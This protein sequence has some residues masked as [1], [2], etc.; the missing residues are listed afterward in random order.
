M[1]SCNPVASRKNLL[2]TVFVASR[3]NLLEVVFVASFRNLLD[4]MNVFLLCCI[5]G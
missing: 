3:K 4:L 5:L 2:E 1:F